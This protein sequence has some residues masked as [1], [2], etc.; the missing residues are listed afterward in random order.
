VWRQCFEGSAPYECE[1]RLRHNSGEFRWIVSRGQPQRD[2]DGQTSWYGTCTDIHER[3]LARRLLED[4]ERRT[5][6]IIDSIPQVIWSAGAD[7][8]LDFVSAQWHDI[9]GAVEQDT[10]GQAWLTAVHPE[11]RASAAAAWTHSIETGVHYETKFRII[12]KSGDYRWA[13]VRALPKPGPDGSALRWYGT[14][15]DIHPQV[16]AQEALKESELLCRGIIEA[17]PNGLSLLDRDG[18]VLFLNDA[19]LRAGQARRRDSLMGQRWTDSLSPKSRKDAEAAVSTAQ[20]GNI[21]QF[22]HHEA[23]TGRWWDVVVAPVRDDA[24]MPTNLVVISRDISAEKA[25]E[26]KVQWAANHDTLTT[27]P[28]RFQLQQRIDHAIVEAARAG[29]SFALL[30]LDIDHFKQINDT[31]GHDAGDELLRSFAERLTRAARPD[32]TIARL[33]GDEFAVVLAGVQNEDEL[34]C[35]VESVF[36]E[37]QSP[38]LFGGRLLDCHAS[39]GASI[40][41]FDGTSRAELLKNADVALYAAKAAGRGCWKSFKPKM[42]E[43]VQK[44]FSMLNLA[45]S[46]LEK[47]RMIPYYQPKIELLTGQVAGFEALL[48]WKHPRRGIQAPATIAAAFEDPT[49]AAEISDRMIDKTVE[50]IRRWRGQGVEFGHVAVNAAAAEFRRGDFA[51]RLLEILAKASV[52]TS[53]LQ[54]EVTETVFLGRGAEFVE[55]A[56][57][58]LSA[59]GVKI[60]LDDFGTGYASLS[61]LKQFPVDYIKIDRSFV[62]DLAS[63]D[64]DGAIIKAVINLGRS[65]GIEIVAEG[66]ETMVQHEM[67]TDWGCPYGQGYLYRRA[68]PADQVPGLLRPQRAAPRRLISAFGPM[69]W[70]RGQ[71]A[72][73]TF[74]CNGGCLALPLSASR[75]I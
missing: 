13:L 7:G 54:V 37:L 59:E 48:R 21:G 12:T 35:A 72:C 45:K 49:L 36:A 73:D 29:G 27:L 58:L 68:V 38:C 53:C 17:T 71:K 69:A 66:V 34:R 5:Q 23:E 2:A 1:Y 70:G 26:E 6:A 25:A 46:A 55:R 16:V 74:V 43:A 67:L 18:T 62:H 32:D 51:E 10:P 41:P 3:V 11:D 8:M 14:C 57:K 60:A 44:R 4:S 50:D 31:L 33:G 65:L 20:Q 63:S 9:Y 39:I 24:G 19:A 56:L 15:T 64:G 61:H 40:Y 22:V 42:R 47:D 75:R 28:N 30:L 52:P